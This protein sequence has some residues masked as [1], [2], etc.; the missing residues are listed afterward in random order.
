MSTVFLDTGYLIAL[1]NK[2]DSL[3][4]KAEAAAHK[5][6]G[7]FITTELIL[8]ELANSLSVS[9]Q[10]QLAL[11]VIDKIRA[12]SFTTVISFGADG[13]EKALSFYRKRS[14]KGWGM[15]DCFSFVTM[16][17]LGIKR[18]LTF[19]EHFKQAGCETPLL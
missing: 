1:I 13:F 11:K 5:F 2:N 14:D 15:I 18:A 17:E 6:Q 7:P 4:K 19:D 9:Q 10:R 12:D 16:D 3:H 8:V